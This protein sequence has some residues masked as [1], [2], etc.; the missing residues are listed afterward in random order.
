MTVF[1]EKESEIVKHKRL[2]FVNQIFR[3]EYVK[4]ACWMAKSWVVFSS[5]ET[6]PIV[7]SSSSLRGS[8]LKEYLP[9]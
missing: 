2:D 5:I 8:A 1:F 3:C 4:A 6:R 9:V 7:S